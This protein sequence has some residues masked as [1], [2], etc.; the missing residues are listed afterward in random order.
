MVIKKVVLSGMLL[1]LALGLIGMA[2]AD[3]SIESSQDF[4]PE[5]SPEDSL[6]QP[7]DRPPV[8][9]ASSTETQ[10][11]TIRDPLLSSVILPL[12]PLLLPDLLLPPYDFPTFNSQRLDQELQLYSRYLSIYGAPDVL[13]VGS[14]RSLQ[15]VDPSALREALAANGYGDLKV[16][17]FGINGATAQVIEVLLTEI[18]IEEQM[19]RLIVWADGT[20]AFNDGREDV[21][22]SGIIASEGYSRVQRGSYPIP[23]RVY[24]QDANA[25][26]TA[27]HKSRPDSASSQQPIAPDLDM[28]GFQSVTAQF[29][30]TAYYRQYPRV[31]GNYDLDYVPF[32]LG[33]MQTEAT[34]AIA[35]FAQTQNILLT[36]VNL[37][38]TDDYL[39]AIRLD[40]ER[41]FRRHMLQLA[42][43][44]TFIYV[45]LLQNPELRQDH[46]FADPSHINHNGARAVAIALAAD[47]TIPWNELRSVDLNA[48]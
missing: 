8:N 6:E 47:S 21:T 22:H 43:Q 7:F 15:G 48:P 2:L 19:P 10:P 39:D 37:P 5:V 32:G 35:E 46:H 13:I 3:G 29:D 18:L 16:Y 44:Q 20:R 12:P 42:Q 26:E 41:Q 38:L 23:S 9:S 40:Y 36:I 28:F 31:P 11:P 4:T 45:D 33:G 24:Y 17:N 27:T 30:P 25:R 34:I 1:T 14:S